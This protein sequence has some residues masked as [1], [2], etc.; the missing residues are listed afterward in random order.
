[1]LGL[2]KKEEEEELEELVE[3]RRI[4]SNCDFFYSRGAY[5]KLRYIAML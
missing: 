1:M 2:L 3:R 4:M 5:I